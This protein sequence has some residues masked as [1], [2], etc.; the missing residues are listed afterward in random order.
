[1]CRGIPYSRSGRWL[2]WLLKGNAAVQFWARRSSNVPAAEMH[3]GL[4]PSVP[5]SRLR[6]M[7]FSWEWPGTPERESLV[8]FLLEPFDGG[9]ELTDG[10]ILIFESG[11]ILLHLAERSAGVP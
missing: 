9:T 7:V 8:T 1:M 11:A 3:N 4:T 5:Q 6:Q 10:D 2:K